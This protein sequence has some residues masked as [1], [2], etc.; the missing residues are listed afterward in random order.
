MRAALLIGITAVAVACGPAGAET[1]AS[2]ESRRAH[3]AIVSSDPLVV[4][5]T[6]FKAGERVKLL[7][8]V[9]GRAAPVGAARASQAGR[10]TARLRAPASSSDAVV[11][12]AIGARGSR[13]T[14]DVSAPT[15]TLAPAP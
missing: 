10:F 5:G 7:V 4:R 13:A 11:V 12:Q 3:L 6:R 9:G 2:E 8:T 1:Q 14:A 15:G